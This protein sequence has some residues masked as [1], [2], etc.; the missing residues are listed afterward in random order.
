MSKQ[1]N[2]V[3]D[4]STVFNDTNSTHPNIKI[5]KEQD[6]ELEKIFQ[7][8]TP[9]KKKVMQLKSIIS[10]VATIMA[11][12]VLFAVISIF[13]RPG[14]VNGQSMEPNFYHGDR[15]FMVKDWM[16]EEYNYNDVVC[17]DID[18]RI[19]IKRIIGLPGDTIVIDNYKVYRN[20]EELDESEYLAEDVRTLPYGFVNTF[21][22][23][24]GEYFVLGDNRE[25][26][27]DSRM[28]GPVDTVMGK[29]WFFFKKSWFE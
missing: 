28:L 15:F 18:G 17:V 23:D 14:V 13:V 5:D 21:T 4:V 20:G 6:A 3:D 9:E 10:W 12:V 1:N 16:I 26:S 2:L 11:A 27:A 8:P 22:V 7:E 24:E 25:N 29:T 19:L